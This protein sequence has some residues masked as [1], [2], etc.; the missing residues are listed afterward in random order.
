MA[1]EALA[2]SK[3]ALGGAIQPGHACGL[4]GDEHGVVQPVD[5]RGCRPLLDH[6]PAE[7]GLPQLAQMPGHRVEALCQRAELIS[8]LH[9]DGAVEV[10]AGD[11]AGGRGERSHWPDDASGQREGKEKTG[12]HQ[13]SRDSHRHDQ[14]AT[15]HTFGVPG[16]SEHGFLIE[17]KQSIAFGPQIVETRLD[18]HKVRSGCAAFVRR[19]RHEAVERSVVLIAVAP[20]RGNDIRLARFGDVSCR[21]LERGIESLPVLLQLS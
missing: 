2:R 18:G 6:Q 5:S 1:N 4:V 11:P 13:C 3:H 20:N 21:A 17:V 9:W 14:R 10:A 8:R 19:R 7:I 15:G 12:H 16:F